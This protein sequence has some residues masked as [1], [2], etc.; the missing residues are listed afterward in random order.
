MSSIRQAVIYSSAARYSMKLI[1]LAST[2]LIARLLTPDEIGTFAIAS[3]IVMIMT[4]FRMLGAGGYLV[5]EEELTAD[6]V[7]RALGLTVIISW[8][9]GA[10]IL[11]SAIPVA[12]FYDLE[13]LAGIFAILALGFFLAPYI[14]IPTSLLSR[15]MEFRVQFK[16]RF[17]GSIVG[18]VSTIGLIL[19][20][21]SYYALAWGQTLVALLNFLMLIQL[22]PRDMVWKPSFRGLGEVASFG[23]FSSATNFLR[24][25]KVTAPDMIIGK[26]GTTT[27]VGMFSRGLGFVEFISQTLMMGVT[28]VA[29]PYLSKTR[30]EG[31]DVTQAYLRASVLLGALVIPVL[32]VASL[33]SLPTIRLFFGLQWD[34]AAPIATWLA[35]WGMARCVHWFANDLLLAAGRERIMLVKEA[36]VLSTLVPGIFWAYPYGLEWIGRAF[37][38][39]GIAEVLI[40]TLLLRVLFQLHV[41]DLLRAWLGNGVLLLLCMAATWGIGLWVPF[42]Q[43]QYWKPILVIALVLP[44]VWLA[45]LALLRHPLFD[46]LRGLAGRLRRKR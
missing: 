23:V 45:G 5:R 20:G 1:G 29:L 33:A 26:L 21:F 14:S 34:A 38:V 30:R 4:E 8:G 6:K 39:A 16:I 15:H 36:L 10:L 43:D 37:L 22:K 7:R 2:M 11:L 3:A 13:P 42:D 27:Q 18:F 17:I 31:G 46:E 9:L 28:P 40:T 24:K 32:G 35:F 19:A 41:T 44:W 25:L 12:R